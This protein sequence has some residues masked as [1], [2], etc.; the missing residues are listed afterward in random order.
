MELNKGG[1]GELTIPKIRDV[2]ICWKRKIV[3]Q[4]RQYYLISRF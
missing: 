3:G 1:G 4:Y 2:A